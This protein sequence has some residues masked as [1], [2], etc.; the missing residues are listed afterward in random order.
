MKLETPRG[1]FEIRSWGESGDPVL[2][3]HPLALSGEV[4]QP[5]G[6]TLAKSGRR[7]LAL[8]ARGHGHS[9][10]DGA[11]FTIEEMAEDVVAVLATL[12]LTR[13]DVVGMSMGGCT[14]L[15]LATANPD[16]V[17]GLVLADTTSS[18]GPRRVETWEQRAR[19]VEQRPREA[20]RDFQLDRWFSEGFRAEQPE[21]CQR[22]AEIFL[23]TDSSAHAAAC[24]AM[25]AFDHSDRLGRVRARTLV[26]VGDEDYATPPEMATTLA[27][28]IP[29]SR[30]EVLSATRHLSLV[31]NR[32]AW[33]VLANHLGGQK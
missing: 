9:A 3:L 6:E 7:V 25:G 1:T 13:T 26:I 31:E 29:R 5:I 22:V 20:L 28:G 14:A 32:D 16:L 15:A 30:L 19:D 17:R 21:E 12:D 11:P 18:Y 27:E 23:L 33:T 4:W 10:W 8:D 24:R 2:F